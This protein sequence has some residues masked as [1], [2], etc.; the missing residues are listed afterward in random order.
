MSEEEQSV[1]SVNDLQKLSI[2]DDRSPA[3]D[4]HDSD[5]KCRLKCD[6]AGG[7]FGRPDQL[8]RKDETGDVTAGRSEN[9]VQISNEEERVVLGDEGDADP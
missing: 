8:H 1:K 6:A 2:L 3:S 5:C 7:A 9:S 4:E